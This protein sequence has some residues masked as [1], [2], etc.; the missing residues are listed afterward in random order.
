MN[1]ILKG[2]DWDE[3][4][5]FLI[6]L[7][8]SSDKAPVL[9]AD[10]L[11]P[12]KQKVKEAPKI[13]EVLVFL[14]QEFD[15][16]DINVA[17]EVV[18]LNL[19]S[20]D[21]GLDD[22]DSD[23]KQ[24]K[25]RKKIK[26]D[27]KKKDKAIEELTWQM[28]DLMINQANFQQQIALQLSNTSSA[29]IGEGFVKYN[30]QGKII[31]KDGSPLPCAA[32]GSGGIAKVLW[33]K[34]TSNKGK[35]KEANSAFVVGSS[36]T[37]HVELQ[38]EG[39]GVISDETKTQSLEDVTMKDI[40]PK[41]QPHLT[42]MEQG[43]KDQSKAKKPSAPKDSVNGTDVQDRILNTQVTLTLKE[44]LGMSVDLQKR[45]GNLVRT[46][47]IDNQ[48]KSGESNSK[49]DVSNAPF[50]PASV[51]LSFDSNNDMVNI[52]MHYANS[53]MTVDI[54]NTLAFT[55]ELNLISESFF[56]RSN[57]PMEVNGMWWSLKGVNG[58]AVPVV[59]L[60]RN[61]EVDIGSH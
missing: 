23:D 39:C 5:E 20:D 40:P 38:Y 28:K 14:Q 34:Q 26:C 7:Y 32:N 24:Y 19:S 18:D 35:I 59:G 41:L 21:S 30:K 58:N 56:Q 61:V 8:G 17:V 13:K 49:A 22:S 3:V 9:T 43:W 16:E 10:K 27:K 37:N 48:G 11:S 53:A 6:N 12:E 46:K 51:Q 15:E 33:D 31:K 47:W 54:P 25:R 55:T 50:V 29:L 1:N 4:K 45:F 60:L 57:I 52:M 36:F 2:A 42:N 44:I